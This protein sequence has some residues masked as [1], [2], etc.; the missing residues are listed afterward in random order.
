MMMCGLYFILIHHNPLKA[1][2]RDAYEV[3]MNIVLICLSSVLCMPEQ[4]TYETSLAK[5]SPLI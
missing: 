5:T 3:K 2:P 4:S 1:K